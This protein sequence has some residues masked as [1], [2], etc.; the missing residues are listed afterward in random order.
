MRHYVLVSYDIT[1][2]R[3]LRRMFRLMRGYGDHIQYSVF[4]CQLTEKD[5]VV[6]IEKIKNILRQ[7]EDQAIV[8]TL[9]KVDGK[10]TSNPDRWDIVGQPLLLSDNSVMIY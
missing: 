6:L 9:G 10:T 1:D 8:M 2:P 7:N 4:L 5:K 3:R